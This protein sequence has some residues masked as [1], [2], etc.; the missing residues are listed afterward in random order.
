MLTPSNLAVGLS[1]LAL[2]TAPAPELAA[3]QDTTYATQVSEGVVTLELS[4]RWEDTL[5]VIEIRANTHSVDLSAI[6]LS[7]QVRLIIDDQEV[8]PVEAGSLSGHHA[9][10]TLAFPLARRPTRF[11][12]RIVDVPDVSPRVLSWPQSEGAP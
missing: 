10:A 5:L 12:L 2:S 11:T 4:P 6:D 7:D 8:T 1:L 9:Q 3:A